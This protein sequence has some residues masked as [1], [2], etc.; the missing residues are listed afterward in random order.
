MGKSYYKPCKE[1]DECNELIE[2][3]FLS[4]QYEKCFEGHL[5]LAEKG[6]P[7][8]ECQIGYF[9]YKGLGIEKDLEKSFYWTERAA[10][11][12]D[13]DAQNN[14]AEFFYGEGVVVE[15]DVEKASEWYKR[16]AMNGHPEAFEKCR[17]L[18]IEAIN[19]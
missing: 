17:A 3:Y 11:H 2:K 7:L 1:F 8:A 5:R 14:L 12:G 9:Y 16:A 13:R 18:G 19:D 4:E 10:R 15:K 6:Y